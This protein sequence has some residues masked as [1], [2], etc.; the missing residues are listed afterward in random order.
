MATTVSSSIKTLE[1]N[2]SGVSPR[3][4]E[5]RPLRW[6]KE[7]YH[8]MND[9]GLF[10]DK[11][12]E[13]IEGE[14]IE[15]AAMNPP[16]FVALGLVG[17]VMRSLFRDGYIVT[18]QSPISLVEDNE[19][20]PDIAVIRGQWRDFKNGLPTQAVVAIEISATTLAYDLGRK[21]ELYARAGILELWVLDVSARQLI[22]HR[23]PSDGK[24]QSIQAL[25]ESDSIAT[26]EKP[27]AAVS[28]DELLP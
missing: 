1:H 3:L 23:E 7:Q 6:T 27:E 25:N 15:M 11:S 17:D 24:Y 12:V 21:A 18:D 8:R 22:V 9:I 19:P 20:E 2:G 5:P 13:L 28:I 10:Q 4:V 26:L 14:I 16:H